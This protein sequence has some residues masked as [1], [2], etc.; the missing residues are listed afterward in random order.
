[1]EEL[2]LLHR[3]GNHQELRIIDLVAAEWEQVAIQIGFQPYEIQRLERDYSNDTRRACWKVFNEWL[4]R[5]QD[6][7]CQ[8]QAL[9]G[10]DQ[11]LHPPTWSSLYDVLV[12]LNYNYAAHQIKEMFS[13]H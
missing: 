13:K 3:G 1:M 11:D 4:C 8:G 2:E 5:G 9:Y 6:L 10:R 7:V 12:K